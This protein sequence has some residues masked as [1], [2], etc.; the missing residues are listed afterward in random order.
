MAENESEIMS[1]E[2]AV[3][4]QAA[5]RYLLG[6]LSQERRNAFEAHYFDCEPCFKQVQTTQDFLH[7]AGQVLDPAPEPGWW[8]RLLGDFRRPALAFVSA[9]LL[10]AVGIGG[11]QRFVIAGLKAPRVEARY[12]LTEGSRGGSARVVQVSRTSALS[13]RVEFLRK[14]EF[15]SYRAQIVSESGKVRQ[16]FAVPASQTE[17][18]VNVSVPA[19]SLT[20]GKYSLVIYGISADGRK[21]ETG[22]GNFNLQFTD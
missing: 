15:V 20:S 8:A 9:M 7:H 2:Q 22:R 1:H 12:V 16:S 14:P 3:S 11:Y 17:D 13:L 4:T 10:C 5:E 21:S 6:E 18:S 19:D